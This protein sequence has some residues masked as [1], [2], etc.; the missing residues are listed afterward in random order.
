MTLLELFGSFVFCHT[1]SYNIQKS[2]THQESLSI[3]VLICLTLACWSQYQV[4]EQK[5]NKNLNILYQ[6]NI[7]Q[8][9]RT[10]FN[11]LCLNKTKYLRI[12]DTAEISL[13]GLSSLL[14][15]KY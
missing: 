8:T 10:F 9:A 2:H 12:T 3:F 4:C 15:S 11:A 1:H 13:H 7:K 5:S 14:K 6:T